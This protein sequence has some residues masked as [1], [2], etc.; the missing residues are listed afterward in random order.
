MAE[1]M[2][3]LSSIPQ[4]ELHTAR[5]DEHIADAVADIRERYVDTPEVGL[6][7]G[8]GLGE[9]AD[10]IDADAIIPYQDIRRFPCSTAVA[11]KGQL[12]CGR[13]AGAPVVAMQG[14]CHLYEGNKV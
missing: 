14:R 1:R 10:E 7:L 5:L 11:H 12:V 8:T 2:I 3:A 6:I 13:L 9:L 4:A